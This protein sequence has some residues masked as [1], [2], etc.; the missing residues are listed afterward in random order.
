MEIVY[1][2]RGKNLKHSLNKLRGNFSAVMQK[3]VAG[4]IVGRGEFAPPGTPCNRIH[5]PR[6]LVYGS[7]GR[8]RAHHFQIIQVRDFHA[9]DHFLNS[10]FP[11]RQISRSIKSICGVLTG[12][13]VT[14]GLPT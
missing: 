2:N 10:A 8:D 12:R 14:P 5:R 7:Y 4:F 3:T 1:K 6:A 13:I 11:T 9:T